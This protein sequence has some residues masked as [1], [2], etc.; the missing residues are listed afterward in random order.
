MYFLFNIFLD[1]IKTGLSN[2]KP[3]DPPNRLISCKMILLKKNLF[4]SPIESNFRSANYKLYKISLA[5]LSLRIVRMN[6]K[7]INSVVWD[8]DVILTNSNYCTLTKF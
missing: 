2:W 4:Y 1:T 3:I 8:Y 6:E 5:K 7:C